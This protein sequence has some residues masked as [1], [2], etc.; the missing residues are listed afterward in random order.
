MKGYLALAPFLVVLLLVEGYP[1]AYALYLSITDYT[2]GGFA[3]LSNYTQLLTTGYFVSA[4]ATTLVYAIGSTILAMAIGVVLAFQVSLLRRWKGVL[5]SFLLAPLAAAPVVAGVIW[6]PSGVWDDINT[7]WH[8]IL[9][10]PFFNPASSHLFLL[11]MILS[12]AWEWAPLIMLVALGIMA[13]VPK[14]IY[15]A[16]EVSGASRWQVFRRI[17]LPAILRS[18]VMQFVIVIRLVDAMRTFEIPFAWSTWIAFPQAGSP[19]DTVSLLLFKLFSIPLY[20][21]PIGQ[22]SAMAVTLLLL[23]LSATTVLFRLLRRSR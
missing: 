13:A 8:F 16:A 5:E 19:V 11:I 17:S 20:G 18:P 22:I 6:A 1:L 4:V 15:E 21:F 14:E 2:T 9:G 23:T 12:D 7:F 3:G 10:Q